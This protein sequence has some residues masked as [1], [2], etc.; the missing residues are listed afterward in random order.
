MIRGVELTFYQTEVSYRNIKDTNDLRVEFA[1]RDQRAHW[2]SKV[3]P[4]G[5][6]PWNY[7]LNG[8]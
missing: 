8:C 2:R 1:V 5:A 6:C 3:H 4:F 7:E